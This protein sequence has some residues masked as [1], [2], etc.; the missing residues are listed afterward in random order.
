MHKLVLSAALLGAVACSP[1]DLLNRQG[2][3][4]R[5]TD[6]VQTAIDEK[7][8]SDAEQAAKDRVAQQ[9][10]AAIDKKVRSAQAH[11]D[12]FEYAAAANDWKDVYRTTNDPQYLLRIAETERAMGDCAEAQL[13]YQQYL[14]KRGAAPDAPQVQAR[15]AEARK[16]QTRA[17][18]N[19]GTIRQHYESGTTHYQLS[20]YAAAIKDFK[21]AFRLSDDPAY[22]FNI[23]QCYRLSK[24]C[25]EAMRY[26]QRYLSVAVDIPNRDKVQ[27][28]IDEM[29]SCAH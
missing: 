26:Y 3:T 19:S 16:C 29:K 20:E 13:M 10:Q 25:G 9:Q 17:G 4:L 28:R 7:R 8:K 15:L 6:Y 18:S 23:G 27:A 12:L 24:N 5:S 14:D 21:E 2:S 22:L 11:A 1:T